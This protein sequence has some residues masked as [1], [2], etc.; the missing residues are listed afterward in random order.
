MIDFIFRRL[1][2]RF[3]RWRIARREYRALRAL[4]DRRDVPQWVATWK[5]ENPDRCM[6]CAFTRWARED[7]DVKLDLAPHNCVENKSPPYPL[8]EA[9]VLS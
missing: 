2:A 1:A 9:K 7:Q 6:Y 3:W 8:P 5:R 4:Q